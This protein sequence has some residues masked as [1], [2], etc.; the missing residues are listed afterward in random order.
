MPI[1]RRWSSKNKATRDPCIKWTREERQR[2]SVKK[3]TP[4]GWKASSLRLN[5]PKNSLLNK[6]LFSVGL[7]FSPVKQA[8]YHDDK[9]CTCVPAAMSGCG[10]F[11]LSPCI[12]LLLKASISSS[13]RIVGFFSLMQLFLKLISSK[14]FAQAKTLNFPVKLHN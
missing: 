7:I 5:L 14:Y 6:Y 9:E 3:N 1:R 10:L 11:C 8:R 13:R 2:D 12:L 4:G